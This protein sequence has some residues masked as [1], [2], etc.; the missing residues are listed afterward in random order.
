MSVREH[1]LDDLRGMRPEPIK[2]PA[3]ADQLPA[4][5]R[6]LLVLASQVKD[7]HER[8]IAIDR[9]I[10]VAKAR[11]PEFFHAPAQE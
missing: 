1:F 9:A 5:A 3:I 6:D 11:F 4:P 2:A 8:R 7:P 10:D